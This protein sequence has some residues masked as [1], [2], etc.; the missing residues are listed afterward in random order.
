MNHYEYTTSSLKITYKFDR[1][2]F[3][4][5]WFTEELNKMSRLGWEFVKDVPYIRDG[6][7]T[8]IV[9]IFRRNVT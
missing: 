7:T 2:N 5:E 3:S 6:W 8:E 4:K 1:H 9:L